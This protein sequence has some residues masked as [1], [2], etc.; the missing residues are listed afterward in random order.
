MPASGLMRNTIRC[1]GG[2]TVTTPTRG[3]APVALAAA[4]IALATATITLA[5]A[6]FTFTTA[7]VAL[8]LAAAA[9][10]ASTLA[11]RDVPEV[12]LLL[13]VRGLGGE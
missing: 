3:R 7:T 4:T 1:D 11:T 2:S 9:I 10:V 8:T 12:V 13:L 5:A 6:S